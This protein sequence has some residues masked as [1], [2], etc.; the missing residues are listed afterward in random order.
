[1]TP[2]YLA[3]FALLLPIGMLAVLR[4][5]E[6]L[7]RTSGTVVLDRR[8]L[9]R[10]LLW[11]GNIIAVF[12]ITGAVLSDSV[13]GESL[14][15]DALWTAIFG[16]C[17]LALLAIFTTIG[18]KALLGSRLSAQ[19]DRDNP[20]AGLAAAA[21]AVATG[22]ITA[23]ALSGHSIQHLGL[24]LAFFLLCQLSLN[25]MLVGFRALTAYDDAEEIHG[26]NLAAALSYAGVTIAVALVVGRA[27]EGEFT[28][29]EASLRAYA[30]AL[31]EGLLIYPARQIVVEGLILGHRPT[32]RGGPLDA[33][34]GAGRQAGV[35]A[36]E[37]ATYFAAAILMTHL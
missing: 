21:H 11:C 25:L 3:P 28:G 33:A 2:R 16:S 4:L 20:A 29:W 17:S 27:V 35:G 23:K 13:R 36:L 24:S 19:L 31:A 5:T 1:M 26:G 6:R 9:A 32:L 7:S 22:I 18:G 30:V 34:I 8:N 10:S 14:L 37:G 12:L 15:A